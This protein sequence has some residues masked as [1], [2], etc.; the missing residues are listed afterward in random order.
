MEVTTFGKSYVATRL[1]KGLSDLDTTILSFGYDDALWRVTAIGEE[2]ADDKYGNRGE[3]RY[4]QLATTL[5]KSYKLEET[6]EHRPYD[7]F[8]S[9][10]ENFA[11][12]ISQNE[13][14]WYRNFRS[15][16]ID[17]ELSLGSNHEDTYWRIIYSHR[18]AESTFDSI[19]ADAELE[20]L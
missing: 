18:A 11:Y 14:W 3:A 20:A 10:A 16:K 9:K 6:F 4:D 19:K 13:A 15:P 1:P 17:I 7:G 2:N 8:Y 5:A 12:A